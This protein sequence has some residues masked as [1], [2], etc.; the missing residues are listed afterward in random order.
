[1]CLP[2]T[3]QDQRARRAAKRTPKAPPAP[4]EFEITEVPP[5]PDP[6]GDAYRQREAKDAKRELTKQK[7]ALIDENKELR[8]RIGELV[9]MQQAPEI[10]IYK[11]ASWARSDA[12][13]CAIASD[14]H[15]EE[16]VN[17]AAV[18]GLNAYDL[19]IAKSRAEH[20]F[21]NLLALALMMGRESKITTLVL[22]ILGD[23]FSGH[24]H[25]ELMASTLLNPGDAARFVKGL[26]IS[27]IDFLLRES[28][29]TL[30]LDLIPGNHGRMTRQMWF[31]DPTGTSLETFMYHAL[32]GRYE[33][34][35]RVQ[36]RVSDHAMVYRTYYERFVVRK[37]HGYEVKYGGGVGGLTIP[38]N[39]A[40][41]QW[42]IGVKADL[43]LLGHFHQLFDG[44]NFIANGSLIGYNTYAQAIKAKY[45][46]PRQAF[47]LI[48]ARKGGCKSVTAPIWLDDAHKLAKPS[49]LA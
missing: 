25:E 6:L 36:M 3:L 18:H 23:L 39:K 38:L 1:M 45:E 46:E 34:N 28:S 49:D 2:C 19:E 21:K 5:P 29:L 43:T 48:N 44:G 4:D 47:Y 9:S 26:L 35:P 37:I 15:V 14:W 27:G 22:D 32:A 20:F 16:E 41:A 42:D 31:S 33:G 30:Q 17:G 7:D 24:I 13:A 8:Q 10:L 11:K 40:I 12:I